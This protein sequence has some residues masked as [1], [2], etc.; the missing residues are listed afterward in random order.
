[1]SHATGTYLGG[2]RTIDCLQKRSHV[3]PDTDCWHWRMAIVQ[4]TP[5]VH[6]TTPDSGRSISMRGRRAALYLLRGIDVPAGHVAY[7]RMT[8]KSRDCVNP[9]HS[10]S[11]DRDAHGLW[12]RKTGAVAGLASKCAGSRK[13]WE[14]RRK[15]TPE[16]VAD[17]RSS[18]ESN[19]ALAAR[20]GVSQ[21]AIWSCRVGQTHR[22][23]VAGS[24]VFNW[25][26]AAQ[27]GRRS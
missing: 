24:S 3:C 4:G 22:N 21:F 9:A 8:C 6:F 23:A 14:G 17:I 12:L 19:L 5:K 18:A 20:W 13:G 7:P 25:I 11:G 10:T 27:I 16:A 15:L 26:P 1:M 2:I